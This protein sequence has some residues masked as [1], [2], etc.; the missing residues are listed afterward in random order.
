MVRP[1]PHV[2]VWSFSQ[3]RGCRCLNHCPPPLCACLPGNSR[4]QSLV[5][6]ALGCEVG[7]GCNAFKV[8]YSTLK[9]SYAFT[10]E[11][12][13]DC[14]FECLDDPVEISCPST[15]T[16][17][18]KRLL[19]C[20]C[21]CVAIRGMASGQARPD[22]GAHPHKQ[23]GLCVQYKPQQIARGALNT[24]WVGKNGRGQPSAASSLGYLRKQIRE[25][26][27]APA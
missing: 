5:A 2:R 24:L 26:P 14:A 22:N 4:S 6:Q 20:V 9:C 10:F 11:R 18:H 23:Q 7:T 1:S 3:G 12:C 19:Q 27:S 21:V 25:V 17:C 15:Q 8:Q 16:S 13:L